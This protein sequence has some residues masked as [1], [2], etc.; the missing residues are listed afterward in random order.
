MEV[1]GT[2]W[3]SSEIHV[4]GNL[5]DYDRTGRLKEI[6]VSTLFTAG[7]YDEATPEITAWYQSLMPGSKLEIFD[8]ASN[9]TM[10]EKPDSYVKVVR[11]FLNRSEK[12]RQ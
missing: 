9:L 4:T 11:E 1:Y 8:D 6:S 2:M 3:G 12:K 7:R 5:K 10:V